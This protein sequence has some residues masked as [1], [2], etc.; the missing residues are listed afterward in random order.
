MPKRSAAGIVHT[1]G[2][3]SF[4]AK[5][6]INTA[7]SQTPRT[8]ADIGGC[9]SKEPMNS[10]YPFVAI[11]KISTMPGEGGKL[12]CRIAF[13]GALIMNIKANEAP[14]NAE[15][16]NQKA[17]LFR[18]SWLFSHRQP[19]AAAMRTSRIGVKD[20][21]IPP[22]PNANKK[23]INLQITMNRLSHPRRVIR[24]KRIKKI[25]PRISGTVYALSPPHQYNDCVNRGLR[26]RIE[27]KRIMLKE[28]ETQ[29]LL[30]G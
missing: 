17:I 21:L 7:P 6:P 12:A 3:W 14:I 13:P 25:V 30:L 2:G 16:R 27:N 9:V 24:R 29:T 8:P 10:K 1:R 20:S 15:P 18:I 28:N 19:K 5:P 11:L 22:R 4:A 23:D 26:S